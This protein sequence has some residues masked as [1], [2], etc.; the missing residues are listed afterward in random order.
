MKKEYSRPTI[1]IE[2][3]TIDDVITT[4]GLG[5]NRLGDIWTS[6]GST[7]TKEG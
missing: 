4:S 2:T 5:E 3:L 6:D 1:E 7:F